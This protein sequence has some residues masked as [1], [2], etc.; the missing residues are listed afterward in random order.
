MKILFYCSKF[1]PLAGGAGIDAFQLGK[2]L[3]V[4]NYQVFVVCEGIKGL[5]KH[6]QMNENFHIYR[7]R[8]P[9][10]RKNGNGFYF[11]LL[12]FMI[13]MKGIRLILRHKIDLLHIHDAA[14]GIAGLITHF[15]TKIPTVF[16]F[17]GSMTYEYMCN[18]AGNK[19]NPVVGENWVWQNVH[20]FA[21]LVFAI[22]K[23][24]YYEFD[25]IYP[26]AKYL[27]NMLQEH[28]HIN[29][30]KVTI[31]H[32]GVDT[33]VIK[34]EKY[35]NIKEKLNIH[36]LIFTGVRFIRCKGV[37]VLINACL[38]I[39]NKYDAHLVI[40]G[41]GPAEK[42]LKKLAQENPRI[43]F[44]GN[45]SWNENLNYV[46][47]ADV[48]VLPSFVDKTPSCLME[49]LALEVPCIASDIAG[50][51]ELITPGGGFLVPPNNP[52]AIRDKIKWI[53]NHPDESRNMG[54]NG[55]SFMKQ[56]FEWEKT[57]DQIESLYYN[58]KI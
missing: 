36:K 3:S 47:S 32:N 7:E 30:S 46:R 17:G 29:G 11:L 6:E 12:C 48:F 28:L 15:I 13:G 58:L 21:K 45:L 44:T 56:N 53:L 10:F 49:A 5:P 43:L 42:G 27:S 40:S 14:T 1:P 4:R 19:W 57:R 55:R 38:P 23:M 2:D 16:K 18:A 24:F 51:K 54:I 34:K 9:F 41:S 31:I 35:I 26:I 37:D 25:C 33:H 20:G 22:E 8:A 50:I 52:S 39:L